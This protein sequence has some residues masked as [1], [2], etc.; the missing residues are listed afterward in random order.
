MLLHVLKVITYVQLAYICINFKYVRRN[1][2]F[3]IAEIPIW[4]YATVIMIFVSGFMAFRAM[5][6][7]REVEKEHIEREGSIY[8]ERMEEE[9]K[10]RLAQE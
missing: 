7:E 10:R 4:V 1:K 9:K 6:S 2:V 5:R 3:T 8:I